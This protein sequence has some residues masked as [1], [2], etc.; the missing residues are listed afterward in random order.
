MQTLKKLME[1]QDIAKSS[2]ETSQSKVEKRIDLLNKHAIKLEKQI[3]DIFKQNGFDEPIYIDE[4][5]VFKYLELSIII[6]IKNYLSNTSNIDYENISKI[7]NSAKYKLNLEISIKRS[8][9]DFGEDFKILDTSDYSDEDIV[10]YSYSV[11]K[12]TSNDFASTEIDQALEYCLI[13]TS[14]QEIDELL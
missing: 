8:S 2:K 10:N 1:Q 13:E 3:V 14:K 7:I 6:Q 4:K 11:E 9:A 12:K 5:M